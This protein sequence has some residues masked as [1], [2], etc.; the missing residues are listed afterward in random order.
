MKCSTCTCILCSICM[1]NFLYVFA[2]I[3]V[4]CVVSH[5]LWKA[6]AM[7]FVNDSGCPCHLV[8]FLHC[9]KIL[10]CVFHS[11]WFSLYTAGFGSKTSFSYAFYN[12]KVYCCSCFLELSYLVVS[13]WSKISLTR[14]MN[15]LCTKNDMCM[16][17]CRS[18]ES[19]IWNVL[20]MFFAR[21]E[22]IY[23][24]WLMLKFC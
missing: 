24:F 17:G 21:L 11:I 15:S 4:N 1:L 12:C 13:I 8:L 20:L 3:V 22:F 14:C 2:F 9:T 7:G 18:I 5:S 6:I 16:H 23:W 19:L 10:H